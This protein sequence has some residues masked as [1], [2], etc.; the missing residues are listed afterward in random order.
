MGGGAEKP[1][2]GLGEGHLG[3]DGHLMG[4]ALLG[5]RGALTQPFQYDHLC[6]RSFAVETCLPF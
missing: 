5:F 1:R 4:A 2:S 3:E 6:A